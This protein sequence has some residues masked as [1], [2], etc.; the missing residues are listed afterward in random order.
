MGA[1]GVAVI[2][3]LM[4]ALLVLLPGK[5]KEPVKQK[6]RAPRTRTT[7]HTAADTQPEEEKAPAVA[8]PAPPFRGTSASRRFLAAVGPEIGPGQVDDTG[9]HPKW[10]TEVDGMPTRLRVEDSFVFV[11]MKT[12]LPVSRLEL[13]WDPK[14]LPTEGPRDPFE[15]DP[16]VFVGPGLTISPG[17]EL[18]RDDG[19]VV[20]QRLAEWSRLDAKT[21]EELAQMMTDAR[22]G[23]LSID[24]RGA[25]AQL[26]EPLSSLLDPKAQALTTVA[27]LRR[28]FLGLASLGSIDV[29]QAPS[30]QKKAQCSYCQSLFVWTH[31]P[32]CSN[33]GAPL[34]E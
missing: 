14:M 18:G 17:F 33:C 26:H 32:R 7:K 10:V 5:K 13:R 30:A 34:F 28:V 1:I 21:Q 23:E 15:E 4:V 11:E 27:T 19:D 24:S 3:G 20:E 8:K 16:P 9:D 22:V 25:S 6:S 31:A 29:N 12:Q 2:L